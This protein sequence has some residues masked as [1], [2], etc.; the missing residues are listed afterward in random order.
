MCKSTLLMPLSTDL[1]PLLVLLTVG[2]LK[3]TVVV[4]RAYMA[5]LPLLRVLPQASREKALL[6]M[7]EGFMAEQPPPAAS[8]TVWRGQVPAPMAGA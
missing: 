7:A 3:K 6:E 4:A 5:G 1:T 2:C 8:H